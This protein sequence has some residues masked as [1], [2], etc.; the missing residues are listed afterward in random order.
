MTMEQECFWIAL[1][2]GTL[3][4][5]GCIFKIL[6]VPKSIYPDWQLMLMT[7]TQSEDGY[8]ETGRRLMLM[9]RIISEDGHLESDPFDWYSGHETAQGRKTWLRLFAL[10][11]VLAVVNLLF[12]PVTMAMTLF[13]GVQGFIVLAC[14]T[15]AIAL[16]GGFES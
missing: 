4:Q 6:R 16:C 15:L 3:L 2:V 7:R 14:L 9:T 1:A 11:S 10:V 5:L 8:R 12:G 13:Y